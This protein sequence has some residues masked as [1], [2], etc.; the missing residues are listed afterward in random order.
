MPLVDQVKHDQDDAPI[1]DKLKNLLRIAGAVQKSGKS[2]TEADVNLAREAG[3]TDIEKE[4][5]VLHAAAFCM[6]NRYVDELATVAPPNPQ[7]Y[8]GRASEVV[9]GGY[10]RILDDIRTVNA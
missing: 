2:V 7:D 3:A 6:Y 10:L 9:S 5:A 8:K 4:D 1:S